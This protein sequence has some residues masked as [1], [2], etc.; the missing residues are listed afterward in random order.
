MERMEC[1]FCKK[2]FISKSNLT[3]HQKTTKYCLEI[4]GK[5]SGGF[6]CEYCHKIYTQ[7][8]T[9]HSHVETCKEK[10]KQILSQKETESIKQIKKLESEITKLKRNEKENLQKKDE[11][12]VEKM[13]EK[14]A[15]Y[16]KD[17]ETLKEKLAEKNEYIAKLE[18]KLEKIEAKLEAKLD[19]MES[20]VATMAFESKAVTTAPVTTNNTTTN[21][22]VTHNNVLNLSK[23]HVNKVLTDHLDYNV[24]YAGQAGFAK[25]VVDKMLKSPD[26]KLTY[27]CVD[28]SRQMFE[29]VNETGETVRDMR[30]E[31]LI[32]SLLDGDALK[33][34]LDAAAKGWNTEDRQ[35]NN[36]RTSTFGPRVTEYTEL[37]RN[38]TVFRNKVSSLT[39]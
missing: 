39:T 25:F 8:Q 28:P 23:E 31:K 17:I 32:Q 26:G 16:M 18:S 22:T 37:N 19:K 1:E 15:S 20:A 11:Y 36:D 2:T 27:K 34:G 21:I 30:A 38:N 9:L 3:T 10:E 12:H 7:S 24:V 33:I 4:Q 35:L 29:F 6:K 13:K 5:T 14:E